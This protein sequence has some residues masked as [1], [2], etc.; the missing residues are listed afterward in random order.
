MLT[1]LVV[2]LGLF[3]ACSQQDNQRNKAPYQDLTVAEFKNKMADPNVVILDVRTPQ[4]T[5]RGKIQGA[6][7]LDYNSPDFAA[8][9]QQLDKS[10]TYLVYCAVGGRSA[11]ACNIMSAK[12]FKQLYNLKSGYSGWKN[13]E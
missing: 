11:G 6:V 9:L 8:K 10:K 3:T 1:A 12:G 7:E 4:E 5:S 2:T 13:A